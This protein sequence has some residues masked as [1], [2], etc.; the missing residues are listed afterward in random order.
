MAVIWRATNG[1]TEEDFARDRDFVEAQEIAKGTDTVY[2]N[3]DSCI[4]G[5][6]P[7]EPMFKARM[8]AGMNA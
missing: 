6:K 5:T 1:W 7:I 4:S 2:V 8:L 3:G